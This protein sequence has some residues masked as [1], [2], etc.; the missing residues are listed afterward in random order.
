MAALAACIHDWLAFDAP[1]VMNAVTKVE[2]LEVMM[3][4][5]KS[6]KTV[7]ISVGIKVV[8]YMGVRRKGEVGAIVVGNAVGKIFARAVLV[9]GVVVLGIITRRKI[10]AAPRRRSV[11]A[12][13]T[14]FM[15][16]DQHHCTA[17]GALP[18]GRVRHSARSG[19]K[20]TSM[21]D[22]EHE[23]YVIK[24]E[25]RSDVLQNF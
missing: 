9:R 17:F 15:Q 11:I 7:D 3:E 12:I 23:M 8:M 21:M 2:T 10:L 6:V 20:A 16:I 24:S 18:M 13:D 25:R 4:I 19:S 5:V 1:G 14:G 22:R